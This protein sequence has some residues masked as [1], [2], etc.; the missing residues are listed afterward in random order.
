MRLS[1]T[2][3][4]AAAALVA[5][6]AAHA[7]VIGDT[8]SEQYN[9][10]AVG[11]GLGAPVVV[12]AGGPAATDGGTGE[13]TFQFSGNQL[14]LTY[15]TNNS[16]TGG[17]SFNGPI[18]TDESE[19]LAGFTA[20]LDPSSTQP[21]ANETVLTISGNALEVDWQGE[22][23]NFGDTVV[24]D[25]SNSSVA[26]TPEPSSLVLLGTGIL[27]LAGAARRRFAA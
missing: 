27:G 25:L 13:F 10:P 21:T 1:A 14:I 19:S 2:L 18:F 9:F 15:I 8:I 4:L 20:T 3:A 24:I 26:A 17:V 7:N 16:W 11:D 22:D 23:E 6:F 12:V 5:P